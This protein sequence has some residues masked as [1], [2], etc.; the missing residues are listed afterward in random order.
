M[1]V[2]T[3]QPQRS[4][5]DQVNVPLSQLAKRR[6]RMLPRYDASN[7]CVSVILKSAVNTRQ[8]PKPN[9]KIRPIG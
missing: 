7:A 6:I 1:R 2:T 8:K 5:I 4:R 9:K 3:R